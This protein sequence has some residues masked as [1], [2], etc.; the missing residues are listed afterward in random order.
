[1]DL[2][3]PSHRLPTKKKLN[4]KKRMFSR[5][6]SPFIRVERRKRGTCLRKQQRVSLLSLTLYLASRLE[7]SISI[8]RCTQ[9][10]VRLHFSGQ[11]KSMGTWKI[12]AIP[13]S[14]AWAALGSKQTLVMNQ[15]WQLRLSIP[16]KQM[17]GKEVSS[18]LPFKCQRSNY[19]PT[20]VRMHY[21]GVGNE[22]NVYFLCQKMFLMVPLRRCQQGK[23]RGEQNRWTKRNISSTVSFITLSGVKFSTLKCIRPLE[24]CDI[25]YTTQ[26][27]KHVRPQLEDAGLHLM[28]SEL[29]QLQSNVFNFPNESSVC[30]R[31]GH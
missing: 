24:F 29:R 18:H 7:K 26:S 15:R 3:K 12:L 11:W 28:M 14:E 13:T 10:A 2:S 25:T 17:Q 22:Y 6:Q 20:Y 23:T 8:N 16:N 5:S 27:N 4:R 21:Q 1:M 19:T 31:T 9:L 30:R